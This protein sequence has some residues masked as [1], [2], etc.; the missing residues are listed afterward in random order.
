MPRTLNATIDILGAES[1]KAA[2]KT[3]SPT[4]LRLGYE[5][6]AVDVTAHVNRLPR[7]LDLTLNPDEVSY[8]ASDPI[9]EFDVRLLNTAGGRT[10]SLHASLLNL[11]KEARLRK[12]SATALEFTTPAGAIGTALLEYSSHLTNTTPPALTRT[13]QQYVAAALGN[14]YALGAVRL[15]G[16]SNAVVDTGSDTDV[17]VPI[18]VQATHTA[19]PFYLDADTIRSF[20]VRNPL[21]GEYYTQTKTRSVTGSI[22]NLPATARVTFSP[23]SQAF[24]YT[25]SADIA[26]MDFDVV[27]DPPL[28]D[29]ATKSHLTIRGMPTGLTGQLDSKN[30]RFTASLGSGDVDLLELSVTSGAGVPLPAGVDGVRLEDHPRTYAAFA[31]ITGLRKAEIAWGGSQIADVTHRAGRFELHVNTSDTGIAGTKVDMVI[32]QLPARRGSNT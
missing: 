11:P 1:Y 20:T 31:R 24:T 27:S 6:G 25:G 3:A 16:L 19:G 12:T 17:N 14:N 30:E 5:A 21:T 15:L 7:T 18:V 13:G 28:F 4:D 8:L 2:F 10:T 23:V 29:S 32:S 26:A 22:L 9:G